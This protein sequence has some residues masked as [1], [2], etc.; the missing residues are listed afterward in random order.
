MSSSD[1]VL[2]RLAWTCFLLAGLVL[3]L[4]AALETGLL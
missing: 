3:I 2:Q 1:R 4:T